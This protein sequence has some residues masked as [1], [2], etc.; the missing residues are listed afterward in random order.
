MQSLTTKL[1]AW[2][3]R[4]RRWWGP[5]TGTPWQR[6]ARGSGPASRM[7]SPLIAILFNNLILNMFTCSFFWCKKIGWYLAVMCDFK[8]TILK[9]PDLSLPPCI[10]YIGEIFIYSM[11]SPTP[12]PQCMWSTVCFPSALSVSKQVLFP[13]SQ[14]PTTPPP[15]PA[16]ISLCFKQYMWHLPHGRGGGGGGGGVQC[17][18]EFLR[19]FQH[20]FYSNKPF[21]T[22]KCKK[23]FQEKF[24]TIC[25]LYMFTMFSCLHIIF[26]YIVYQSNIKKQEQTVFSIQYINS[27]ISYQ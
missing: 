3:R 23:T 9:I 17:G 1:R 5:L 6:P 11:I 13:T 24:T 26:N 21:A 16:R 19:P 7:L 14:S 12:P 4:W 8:K 2:S 20:I 10:L 18:N 25:I 22:L 27:L 15:P